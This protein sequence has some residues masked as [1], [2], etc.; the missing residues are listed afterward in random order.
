M[1]QSF[2]VAMHVYMSRDDGQIEKGEHSFDRVAR[3]TYFVHEFNL[4][5]AVLVNIVIVVLLFILFV[6]FILVLVLVAI[7]RIVVGINKLIYAVSAI[8]V[9]IRCTFVPQG[10]LLVLAIHWGVRTNLVAGRVVLER[11]L[12]HGG[13][14]D[15]FPVLSILALAGGY[16]HYDRKKSNTYF[17][18]ISII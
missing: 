17:A 12:I 18:P 6:L 10:A 16:G 3:S 11:R 7:V 8:T 9:V 4:K 2:G 5:K 1:V 13:C 14:S 15:R